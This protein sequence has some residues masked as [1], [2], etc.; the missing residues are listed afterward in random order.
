MYHAAIFYVFY[1][2][3]PEDVYRKR[4]FSKRPYFLTHVDTIDRHNMPLREFRCELSSCIDCSS[5][6][7]KENIYNS[8]IGPCEISSVFWEK[9][10]LKNTDI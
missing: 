5:I 10:Y 7:H 4:V 3:N 6:Y 2:D 1:C 8:L 9:V